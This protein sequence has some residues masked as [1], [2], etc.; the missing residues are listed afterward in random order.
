M[1][2]AAQDICGGLSPAKSLLIDSRTGEV[3]DYNPLENPKHR[4]DLGES[5]TALSKVY[6]SLLKPE[7]PMLLDLAYQPKE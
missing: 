1:E 6:D 5:I 4:E 2:I 3:E 7:K